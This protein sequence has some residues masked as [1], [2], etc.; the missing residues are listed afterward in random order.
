MKA[1]LNFSNAN[2][3]P[4][5]L[6]N[7]RKNCENCL[8]PE[9]HKLCQAVT[10]R[11]G[12]GRADFHTRNQAIEDQY[13]RQFY[14]KTQRNPLAKLP[15][16]PRS[17]IPRVNR[18]RKP[19][20]HSYR[21]CLNVSANQS[22]GLSLATDSSFKRMNT[23]IDQIIQAAGSTISCE[24]VRRRSKQNSLKQSATKAVHSYRTI[25]KAF[26]H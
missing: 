14:S 13:S 16:V 8:S 18:R 21:S 22:P 24:G 4:L 17:W 5:L 9:L 20:Y 12:S 19:A 11:E 26:S 2:R 6:K 10:A 1:R 3:Q 23:Q 15:E 25:H 7:P